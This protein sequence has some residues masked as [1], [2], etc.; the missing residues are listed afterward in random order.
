MQQAAYYKPQFQMVPMQPMQYPWAA[1]G[2]VP[3]PPM[4]G[5]GGVGD[6]PLPPGDEKPPLPPEPPP[7]EEE[8]KPK[9][10]RVKPSCQHAA[11][12]FTQ[13]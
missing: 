11:C 2:M 4:P 5:A 13:K 9:E 3:Q 6:T 7:V 12:Q 1:P 8:K 10:V